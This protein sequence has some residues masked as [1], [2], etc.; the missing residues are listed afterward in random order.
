MRYKLRQRR[1]PTLFLCG[2]KYDIY[3]PARRK[4]SL[5]GSPSLGPAKDPEKREFVNKVRAF[6]DYCA[7]AH[8]VRADGDGSCLLA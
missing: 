3:F 7:V 8:D 6:D 4:P 2:R 5:N 1:K